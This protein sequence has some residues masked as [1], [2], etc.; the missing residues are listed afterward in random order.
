MTEIIAVNLSWIISL[1]NHLSVAYSNVRNVE[2]N[3]YD[4][5][6]ADTLQVSMRQL[7]EVIQSLNKVVTNP[8]KYM[9][10]V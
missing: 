3:T 4:L 1:Q 2:L 7:H 8:K 10:K 9:L 6:K 5:D